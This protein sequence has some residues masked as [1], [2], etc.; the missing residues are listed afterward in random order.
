MNVWWMAAFALWLGTIGLG[1]M[2][3]GVGG[4]LGANPDIEAAA[5]FPAPEPRP[6]GRVLRIMSATDLVAFKP[7]LLAFQDRHRDVSVIYS[8]Y[9]SSQLLFEHMSL[10]CAGKPSPAALPD[11][12]LSSAMNL[13]VELVNAGCA[14]SH[15]APPELPDWAKWR[16]ELFGLTM[17]PV[18]F[19]YRKSA[20]AH[21]ADV[22]QDRFALLDALRRDARRLN[23]RVGTYDIGSSGTGYLLA[24]SDSQQATTFGR[25]MEGLAR[26]GVRLACCTSVILDGLSSGELALGYNVLGSYALERA[27]H[28][29]EI[30]IVFPSD[31]TLVF[32]RAAF[33]P[34]IA[35][36]PDLAHKFMDFTFSPHGRQIMRDQ[37]SMTSPMD[38]EAALRQLYAVPQDQPL[39]LRPIELTSVL[40]VGLDD[41]KRR[42]LLREWNAAMHDLAPPAQNGEGRP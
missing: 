23:R 6:D 24:A 20:F 33:I 40:L 42:R 32:S 34:K 18:V 1:T 39:K 30:G 5:L 12:V 27:R 38:G 29:P 31:Y 41:L 7:L 28:D 25:M 22:P 10:L 13:Q 17:E 26:A 35:P 15:V 16:N 21:Q 11:L 2:G 3:L 8:E 9:N 36:S 19:A 4:A 14:Q 37:S